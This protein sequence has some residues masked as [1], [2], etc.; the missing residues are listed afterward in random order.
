MHNV[1]VFSKTNC[2]LTTADYYTNV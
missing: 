1:S 2:I